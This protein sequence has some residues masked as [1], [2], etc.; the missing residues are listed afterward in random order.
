MKSKSEA[1]REILVCM[2]RTVW[3]NGTDKGD[4]EKF[5]LVSDGAEEHHANIECTTLEELAKE[6]CEGLCLSAALGLDDKVILE[7]PISHRT[8]YADGY[9]GRPL[10]P[11]HV[12]KYWP[13]KKKDAKELLKYINKYRIR[14]S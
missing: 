5:Y 8:I 10:I 13:L 3:S 11:S 9:F 14:V 7:P 12:E 1:G 4:K 2:V 6:I